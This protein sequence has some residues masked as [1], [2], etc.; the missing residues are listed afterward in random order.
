M[1]VGTK[2]DSPWEGDTRAV[3]QLDTVDQGRSVLFLQQVR[4]HLHHVVRPDAHEIAVE[5]GVMEPAKRQAVGNDR[6]PAIRVR[7]D[8]RRVEQLGMPESA[9]RA[10]PAVGIENAF[11]ERALVEALPDRCRHILPSSLFP[12]VVHGYRLYAG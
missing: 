4:T 10:L 8:M 3:Q 12:V 9:E 2:S 11:P 7:L 6:L 5:R 1:R